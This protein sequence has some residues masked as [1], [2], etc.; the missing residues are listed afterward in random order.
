ML[1]DKLHAIFS[2]IGQNSS[3]LFCSLR[4]HIILF[5][6]MYL[7]VSIL[8]SLFHLDKINSLLNLSSV[9]FLAT[10][11]CIKAISVTFLS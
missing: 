8:F 2:V 7:D 3:I 11:D 4:N 1:S 9:F 10:L 5:P 6:F